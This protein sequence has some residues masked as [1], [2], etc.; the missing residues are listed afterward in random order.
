MNKLISDRHLV[1]ILFVLVFITFSFAYED[2]KQFEQYYSGFKPL[3]PE[4]QAASVQFIKA[5]PVK[6][7]HSFTDAAL[8]P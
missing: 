2:S 1:V 5:N 8:V 7:T 4:H 3:T 6:D